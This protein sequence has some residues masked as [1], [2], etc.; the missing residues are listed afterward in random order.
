MSRRRTAMVRISTAFT[1][2]A[3]AALMTPAAAQGWPSRPVTMIVPFAAGGAFDVLGR[4]VAA[5]KGAV[6]GPKGIVEKKTGARGIDG[7]KLVNMGKTESD[8]LLVW[9]VGN[10]A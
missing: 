4:I 2:V 1:L 5:P 7:V 8:T 6:F 9:A 3:L 10:H